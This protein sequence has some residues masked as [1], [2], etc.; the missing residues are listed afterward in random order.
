MPEFVDDAARTATGPAYPYRR[1]VARAERR[2]D[3]S[4]AR[5]WQKTWPTESPPVSSRNMS[6]AIQCLRGSEPKKQH[7]SQRTEGSPLTADMSTEH[8]HTPW[9]SDG[10]M[11]AFAKRKQPV[12]VESAP[13]QVKK[14][15]RAPSARKKTKPSAEAIFHAVRKP[16]IQVYPLNRTN[17]DSVQGELRLSSTLLE[18]D[19][20]QVKTEREKLRS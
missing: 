15:M 3:L 19:Q 2:S 16:N 10:D 6:L 12:L 17:H 1:L 8:T 7:A 14:D 18:F 20:D 5:T 11:S 9:F 13:N 4:S